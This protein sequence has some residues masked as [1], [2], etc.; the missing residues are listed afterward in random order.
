MKLCFYIKIFFFKSVNI[1]VF[2]KKYFHLFPPREYFKGEKIHLQNSMPKGLIFIKNGQIQIDIKVS[3]FELQYIIEQVF[4][5][6]IKNNFYK[7]VSKYKGPNYLMDLETLKKMK[8]FL[9]EPILE[10]VKHKF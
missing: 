6:M 8:R 7:Q 2:E 3:V 9:K 5:R 10:N 4:E 1:F